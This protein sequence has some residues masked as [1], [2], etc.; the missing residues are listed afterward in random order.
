MSSNN[1]DDIL[2][3]VNDN[4]KI[5]EKYFSRPLSEVK[6]KDE[7]KAIILLA[8]NQLSKNNNKKEANDFLKKINISTI[9]KSDLNVTINEFF[10][11]IPSMYESFSLYKSNIDFL[12]LILK[13]IKSINEQYNKDNDYI[14]KYK[15]VKFIWKIYYYIRS[16]YSKKNEK[17][18]DHVMNAVI[19]SYILE[20]VLKNNPNRD[21]HFYYGAFKEVL[22]KY[23]FIPNA[24]IN[25]LINARPIK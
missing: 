18:N 6:S 4:I 25:K 16:N 2:T 20:K 8:V 5:I 21:H 17:Q 12:Y 23:S 10:A 11:F 22:S 7:K 9:F 14:D 15:S 13:G 3:Y 19:I 1:N 24:L